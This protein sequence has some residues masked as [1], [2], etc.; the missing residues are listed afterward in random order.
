MFNGST[1]SE[2]VPR[3]ISALLELI[4]AHRRAFRQER[5]Y[6]RAVGLVLGELFNFTRQT[7]TQEL[8]ALGITDGDWSAWYR[9]FSRKRFEEGVLNECL[10]KETLEHV[11]EEE[12]YCVAVD[13]TTIHRSS[14]KMPGTSWLRDSRFSAFRPGIHR[15][16]RFLHG[17][18]LTP[19]E[20]GYS[21][22]IPLRFLP[23]FPPKAVP[24]EAKACREW[25]AGLGFLGWV[26]RE[27][28]ELGRAKQTVVA[29]ADGGFDT[30]EMWR[31]LPEGVVLAVRTARNRALYAL[32]KPEIDPGPGRPASYGERAPKPADWLHAGLRNWPRQTVRVRGKWIEMRYQLLGPFVREGLPERPLFLIVVKGMHRQVGKQVQRYKDRDPSFYLVSAAQ[33]TDGS[34]QVPLPIDQLLTWLWQRWEIEVAHR[35]MKTGL[36]IGEKQC[37][38]TRSAA[39]SV[40]WSVWTYAILVLAG[41]RTW[42]LLHG[43]A[44]PARWWPGAKRWSFNTLWRSYR[45][46]LWGKTEFRALWT[47]TGNNWWKKETWLTGLDNAVAS[48]A[49]I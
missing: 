34:W 38:N 28:N 47:T 20:D 1:E 15:A 49:R 31:G 44:T 35:E 42:G 19:L 27:L 48:A 33:P 24:A 26:R 21:R 11:A 6:R 32:P 40:Q 9:L 8:Q 36:G 17:A 46:A 22:A 2:G 5:P 10:L 30:L 41:Y 3:L 29:L 18:W 4:Q 12:P 43:P 25:E 37:W 13:S 7:I 16:Q 39:L 14:L 23:A 45:A